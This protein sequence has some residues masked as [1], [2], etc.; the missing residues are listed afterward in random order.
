MDIAKK[1]NCIISRN[2]ILG[3]NYIKNNQIT[4]IYWVSLVVHMIKNLP[5][6]WETQVQSLGKE[7]PLEK[8]LA[9]LSSILAWGI[10]GRL[11]SMGL[12][13]QT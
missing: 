3:N 13:S 2:M 11:Q 5:A 10:P 4:I 7:G 9:T 1:S 6:M 8:R 12:Q